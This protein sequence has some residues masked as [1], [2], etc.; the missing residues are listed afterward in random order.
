MSAYVISDEVIRDW[1]DLKYTL[2]HSNIMKRIYW[3]NNFCI[4]YKQKNMDS[5]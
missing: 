1:G 5:K 3:L 4:L 2:Y